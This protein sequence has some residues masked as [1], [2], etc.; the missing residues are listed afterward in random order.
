MVLKYVL[1]AIA[2]IMIGVVV[3][4]TIIIPT[5]TEEVEK[6]EEL[7]VEEKMF[8]DID[9]NLELSDRE[10]ARHFIN[11]YNIQH[12]HIVYAQFLLESGYASSRIFREYNNLFG[13][14]APRVRL[15]TSIHNRGDKWA[16]FTSIESAVIDYMIWQRLFANELSETDYFAFLG[17]VYA[18]DPQYI[19]KLKV[20]IRRH[21][22][23]FN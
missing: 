20:L 22:Y 5:K 11:L 21:G 19:N 15:T 14:K 1:V 2:C 18:E 10:I 9:S 13:M 12:P 17:R 23:K 8:E 6:A 4:M 3:T 16:K 7:T